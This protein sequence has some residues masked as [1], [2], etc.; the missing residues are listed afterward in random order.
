MKGYPSSLDCRCNAYGSYVR[1][2]ELLHDNR[3]DEQ[4]IGA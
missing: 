3:G 2:C 1:H 4:S